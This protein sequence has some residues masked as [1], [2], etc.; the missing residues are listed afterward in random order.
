MFCFF[1]T[2]ILRGERRILTPCCVKDEEVVFLDEKGKK[3]EALDALVLFVFC[4]PVRRVIATAAN[5][6]AKQR[7]EEFFN[8]EERRVDV[9]AAGRG[10]LDLAL[11]KAHHLFARG[12]AVLDVSPFGEAVR[13]CEQGWGGAWGGAG[14]EGVI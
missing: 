1:L 7:R 12:R 13:H 9:H 8:E 3:N 6:Q 5:K 14:G 4:F 11:A 2:Q 10:G